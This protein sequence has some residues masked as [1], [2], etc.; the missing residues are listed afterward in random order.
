MSG[1]LALCLVW[2]WYV[3]VTP[4]AGAETH[5]QLL[6]DLGSPRFAVRQ[7]ASRVLSTDPD[8][9]RPVLEKALRSTD[10]EVRRRAELVT[11]G[12]YP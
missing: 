9:Y 8:H 3:G 4:G 6:A 12:E 2:G 11:T 10:P 7:S 1:V 5:R